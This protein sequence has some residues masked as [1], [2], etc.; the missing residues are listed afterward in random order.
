VSEGKITVLVSYSGMP[1]YETTVPLCDTV[2][3]PVAPGPVTVRYSTTL[4]GVAPPVR[5][6]LNVARRDA[7]RERTQP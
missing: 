6:P 5:A 1:V 4:P 7:T 3:C 2:A